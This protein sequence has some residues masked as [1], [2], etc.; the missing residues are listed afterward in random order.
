MHFSIGADSSEVA[1]ASAWL[2]QAGAAQGIPAEPLSRL[3]LCMAEALSN[4]IEHGGAGAG[5]SPISMRLGVAP[6]ANGGEA[7]VTVSDGGATF[8][9]M[10]V[11]LKPRPKTLAEAEP[12]GLGV[13][14]LRQLADALDYSYSEGRNHLTIHVRWNHEKALA[15]KGLR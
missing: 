10:T 13:V 7:S 2:G 8:N 4:I 3:D 14:I 11:P 12:G 1:R 6:S 5:A 9:P 15:E